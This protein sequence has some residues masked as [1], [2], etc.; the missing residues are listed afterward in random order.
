MFLRPG[1][2]HYYNFTFISV[3]T[4]SNIICLYNVFILI[5]WKDIK[6]RKFSTSLLPSYICSDGGQIVKLKFFCLIYLFIYILSNFILRRYKNYIICETKS[7]AISQ[8]FLLQH[9]H[10]VRVICSPFTI[11]SHMPVFPINLIFL[12]GY[13]IVISTI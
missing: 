3:I 4:N 2:N 7:L 10:L 9:V 8:Y 6:F 13:L 1:S 11:R 5:I 12:L